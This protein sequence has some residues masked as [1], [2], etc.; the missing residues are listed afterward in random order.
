MTPHLADTPVLESE[1]HAKGAHEHPAT[2]EATALAARLAAG[3]PTLKTERL[4]LRPSRL[5]DFPAFADL[6]ASERSRY[7]GG[8]MSRDTAWAEFAQLTA[9]WLLHGHGG[10]TVELDGALM[11]FVLIGIEPGDHEREVGYLLTEEAE[12][13]GIATEAAK[14]A[15]DFAFA[16]LG[17]ETLVSYIDLD[18]AKSVAVA[19]RLGGCS[20]KKAEAA[21]DNPMRVYRYPAPTGTHGSRTVNKE[22]GLND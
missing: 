15:R 5:D 22:R 14:A 8:P 17:F 6:L 7:V 19:E 9:G 2:P 11:G 12:G 10:W 3:I 4:V 21:L 20:D 13:Q 1:R 16:E 18:N